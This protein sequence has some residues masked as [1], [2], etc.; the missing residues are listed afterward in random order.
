MEKEAAPKR[1]IIDEVFNDYEDKTNI[2]KC[3]ILNVKMFKKTNK[4]ELDILSK[5][6][7]EVK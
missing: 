2:V 3:E 7:L 1:K 4:L 5:N 6:I